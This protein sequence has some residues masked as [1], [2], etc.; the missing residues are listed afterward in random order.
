[1]LNSGTNTGDRLNPD[2]RIR[3]KRISF[4]SMPAKYGAEMQQNTLYGGEMCSILIRILYKNGI[5]L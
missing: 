5:D 3:G 1:M 2:I 4:Y